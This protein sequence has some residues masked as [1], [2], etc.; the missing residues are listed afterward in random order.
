MPKT[1]ALPHRRDQNRKYNTEER[2]RW[3]KLFVI[4]LPFY[5]GYLYI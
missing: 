5:I 4:I 2:M 3:D 1:S